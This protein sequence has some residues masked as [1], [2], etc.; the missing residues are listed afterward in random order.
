MASLRGESTAEIEATIET[1]W[2]LVE[3]VERA[4]EWQGGMRS[5]TAIE[6]D[7]RNRGML[8][9]IEVDARVAAIK[10]TLR[11][12]YA[13]PG[14]L[15]WVQERGDIKSI[16]G[17]WELE[18]LGE[19]RTRA[20]YWVEVDVGRLGLLIRGPIVSVLRDQLAGR[21]AGELKQAVERP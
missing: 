5:L 19:Q 15:S 11:F 18:S 21:R 10:A 7:D 9:N 3:D 8:C 1:V 20:R 4:P 16:R 14:R 6:R 17:A 13:E 12:T 2:A